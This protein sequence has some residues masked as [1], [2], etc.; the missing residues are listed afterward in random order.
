MVEVAAYMDGLIQAVYD[1][2]GASEKQEYFIWSQLDV[3][4]VRGNQ[5]ELVKMDPHDSFYILT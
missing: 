4:W 3:V 1:R 2:L 5:G